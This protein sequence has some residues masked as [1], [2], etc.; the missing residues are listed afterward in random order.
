MKKIFFFIILIVITSFNL[1]YADFSKVGTAAAQFLK[2][3]VGARALGMGETFVA[4]ANDASSLYWNPAGL[5]NLAS[6]SLAVSH[7]L[8]FAD[9]SHD[10]LGVAFP[11][12]ANNMMGVSVIALN[13]SEQEVTTVEQPDGTGVFYD[14]SDIAIGL[15]YAR[16][17]TDR[18]STGLT[19]KY[20]Q[21]NAY[22]ESAKTVAIDLGTHLKTGFHGMAIAMS[23]TNYGGSLRLEGRDLIALTDID[24]D[25][26]GNYQVD[27][28]L[29][30]E[31][32]PLP[33]N[34]RVGIAMD[35]AGPGD[36]FFR[37]GN[38]RLTLAVDGVHPND[39]VER[40]NLGSE[41][42]WNE[43]IFARAGYK[44]NYDL[45]KWTFG[46]GLKF[47]F[48]PHIMHFDVALVDFGDLGKVTRF[49][50]EMS[51]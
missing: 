51:F 12:G 9:I 27:T 4:L 46:G 30:T 34:F 17:L 29:K 14:V 13:T 44:I 40:V 24:R 1:C 21:Q 8:W 48:G 33:L 15:T 19:V 39:N 2:I 22:N 6:T 5:V 49:S 37:M 10:F 42:A 26:Q 16:A 18:F 20:V 45:E 36:S 3:G 11:L 23:M 50:A 7:S 25:I 43:T 38:N 32:W 31:S 41:Y 47:D 35:I 28:R